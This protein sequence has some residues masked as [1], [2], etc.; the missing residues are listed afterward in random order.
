MAAQATRKVHMVQ[1]REGL[2]ADRSK[3][4]RKLIVV[5]AVMPMSNKF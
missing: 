4:M 3:A 1:D 5:D 2:R